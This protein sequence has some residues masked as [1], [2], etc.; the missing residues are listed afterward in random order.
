[1]ASSVDDDVQLELSPLVTLTAEARSVVK[2]AIAQEPDPD[3]LALWLEVRGIENGAFVYDLYFQPR[4]DAGEDDSVQ[5]DD[6][7]PVVV[8]SGSIDQLRGA[9]LEWSEDGAGG[10]V[11]VN[12]N[13]P[14]P[15]E[16][17]PGV[18]PE[19]L[20]AG[21]A[22]ALAV[23]VSTVIEEVVN[24]SIAGHGGRADLVALDEG[25]GVA[26]LRLSGGCQGCSMSRM[27]LTQG[28]EVALRDEVPEVLRVV[29]VTDHGGGDNPYY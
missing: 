20:A 7:L 23:R 3:R 13:T 28:I 24:P 10:L 4:S 1:M 11:L 8:P 16:T 5:H 2:E 21:L 17:A 18:P 27:T 29:D 6:E 15:E 14:S 19:V 9:R 25:E 26:Y 22:G 12:P